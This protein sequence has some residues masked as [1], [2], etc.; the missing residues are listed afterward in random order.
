MVSFVK[1]FFWKNASKSCVSSPVSSQDGS[2]SC[3]MRGDFSEL[4]VMSEQEQSKGMT[5]EVITWCKTGELSKLQ[6]LQR[7]CTE[8]VFPN[9]RC[10]DRSLSAHGRQDDPTFPHDSG[11][12]SLRSFSDISS[13]WS[14]SKSQLVCTV[15]GCDSAGCTPLMAAAKRGHSTFITQLLA[16]GADPFARNSDG[17]SALCIACAHGR[18]ECVEALLRVN[19]QRMVTMLTKNGVTPL[20]IACANGSPAVVSL[21]LQFDQDINA[22]VRQQAKGL[23]CGDPR[24]GGASWQGYFPYALASKNHLKLLEVLDTSTNVL[25]LLKKYNTEVGPPVCTPNLALPAI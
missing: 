24:G 25:T 16:M 6:E 10:E 3:A 12:C 15:S 17:L 14:L 11:G 18:I 4:S 21:L 9:D 22:R 2:M 23:K 13:S 8:D 7:S 5:Q 1:I 19:G 20:H